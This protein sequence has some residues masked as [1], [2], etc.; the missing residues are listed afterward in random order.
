MLLDTSC[1]NL[2][3]LLNSLSIH[4]QGFGLNWLPVKLTRLG[5]NGWPLNG[6]PSAFQACFKA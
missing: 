1:N 3:F 5:S 4:N 6:D 2:S